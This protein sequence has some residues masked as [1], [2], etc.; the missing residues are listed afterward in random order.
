MRSILFTKYYPDIRP[1][2]LKAWKTL[3]QYKEETYKPDA[4]IISAYA[5]D[6]P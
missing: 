2:I 3:D 1:Y 4:S 6:A 5:Q